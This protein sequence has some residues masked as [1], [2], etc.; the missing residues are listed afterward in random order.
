MVLTNL[1]F[2]GFS[3]WIFTKLLSDQQVIQQV[4]EGSYPKKET[5]KVSITRVVHM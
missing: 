2:L 5:A 3:P 1:I 4:E